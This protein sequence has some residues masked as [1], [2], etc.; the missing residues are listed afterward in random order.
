M[1]K[2]RVQMKRTAILLAI[3]LVLAGFSSCKFGVTETGNP[4]PG[5][6]CISQPVA[7]PGGDDPQGDRPEETPVVDQEGLCDD[8]VADLLTYANEE[9][10][11]K[12]R[13]P[14]CWT[15]EEEEKPLGVAG[16]VLEDNRQP[17]STAAVSV[18]VLESIEPLIAIAQENDDCAP[19]EYKTPTL[20]GYLCDKAETGA[21]GGD[22]RMYYF[23]RGRCLVVLDFE[24]FEKG[25]VGAER[26]LQGL[27]IPGPAFVPIH[28]QRMQEVPRPKPKGVTP[29]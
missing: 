12:V 16:V 24:L 29:P 18:S 15:L 28:I 6:D 22:L 13:Y 17:R 5:G 20:S 2:Q 3:I 8:A 23:M 7:G 10:G 27:E 14:S 4:C 25:L 19:V 21:A 26:I 1:K 9:T 11:V